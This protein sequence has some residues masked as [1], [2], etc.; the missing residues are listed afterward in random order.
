MENRFGVKDFI[1]FVL[2]ALLIG[3]VVLAM[4]QY[5]RQWTDVQKIRDQLAEQ[6]R[7]L[8][9]LQRSIARGVTFNSQGGAGTLATGSRIAS[10]NPADYGKDD[11]FA[12]IKAARAN[13]TYA[14]GDWLVDVA[15]G[16]IA[17][18]T[19]FIASDLYAMRVQDL[20]LETLLTRDPMTLDWQPL[21]ASI[22]PKI[23]DNVEAYN[24]YVDGQKKKGRK[25]EEIWKDP[26]LPI[27]VTMTFTL[28]SGPQFS[29][30]KPIT[31]DDFVWTFNWIM[32]EKVA[33]VRDRSNFE[34]IRSVEKKGE[35]Q[36]VF[37]F[38]E[39][40][41]DILT[42]A[43]SLYALPKHFYEKYQPEQ[44]NQS[45]GLLMGSGPYRLEDPTAW[46]PGSGQV[47]LVR[48]ERYWGTLP[49]F[50]RIIFKEISNDVARQTAFRNGEID[51]L[52][53]R[54][55]Q[56]QAM[57][58][59]RELMKRSQAHDILSLNGGYRYVAWQQKKNGKPT[60]FADQRVRQAMAM[61]V[62]RE[63]MMQELTLGYAELAS[64]P[65]SPA[66][67]QFDPSVKPLPYDVPRAKQ[68]L[69][70]A[71]LKDTQG[72][73]VLRMPD[74]TPF[75]FKLTFPS[76]SAS[77][78]KMALTM[79]DAYAGVGIVM[80]L[81]PLEW[82]VFTQKLNTKD[83][84]AISLGW[85]GGNPESDIFQMFDS[86]QSVT[87]GDNF[88]WYA[89]PRFDEIVRR[90]RTTVDEAKRIPLWHEAQRI[91]NEDQ[92]YMFLW[93][94]KEMYLLDKRIQNVQMGPLGL[95]MGDRLEWWV[96][97]NQQKWIK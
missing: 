92:P 23:D 90:A 49:A 5:D 16:Q 79:K 94:T 55:E 1:L 30:G 56:Y 42:L 7:D 57:K 37:K 36:L 72:D 2:L 24:K 77:Y 17:K 71:G 66:G 33:A 14:E 74:G 21:L 31:A 96:P 4:L 65:F 45:V 61:L 76:G 26:S 32:N 78:E 53:A 58:N 75:R 48:N 73:G 81:D 43:G 34:K 68:L 15:M 85:G 64:G 47:V 95:P 63:R 62:N 60:V 88:M 13:P 6:G 91:L 69:A 41:Y 40:Y 9:D 70:E 35:N 28:R 18:L 46:K 8:R 84:E 51:V 44:Y 25:I 27:P 39:P 89:N 67:K 80:D 12:R 50:D 3:V 87:D 29:D 20:V 82:A 86:S 97:R 22:L 38:R 19:P 52:E 59:D 54:P 10:T 11:P 83:F 93:F